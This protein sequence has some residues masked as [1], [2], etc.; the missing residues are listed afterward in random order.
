MTEKKESKVASA[1]DVVVTE[2]PHTALDYKS[3]PT[4]NE[5]LSVDIGYGPIVRSA[6][7]GGYYNG[8]WDEENDCPCCL[9]VEALDEVVIPFNRIIIRFGYPL[10]VNADFLL[11][12]EGGFTRRQLIDVCS[13]IYHYIYDKED[14]T[15]EIEG[16]LGIEGGAAPAF[17]RCQTNGKYG[18]WG[19]VI[20][21]LQMH[22]LYHIQ[23][24]P[25]LEVAV[26]KAAS[27]EGEEV[28][29]MFR[30]GCDS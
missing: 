16:K 13:D 23:V 1:S 17:N 26:L 28:V 11:N 9:S 10:S 14:E 15:S 8:E 22:S 7:R 25:R 5:D 2:L 27:A 29:H 12:H 20:D 21:D 3:H 24:I 19:H 6:D 30:V 18:I 4:A